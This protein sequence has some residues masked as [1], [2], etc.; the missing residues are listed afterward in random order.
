MFKA[1]KARLYILESWWI[2]YKMSK[3][4]K[5]YKVG[6]V[7]AS[8]F[9][10]AKD[11]GGFSYSFKFQKSYKDKGGQWQTTDGFFLSD[12][13]NL[14]AVAWQAFFDISSK[15]SNDKQEKRTKK[16]ENDNVDEDGEPYNVGRLLE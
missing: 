2:N 12:I 4:I 15:N 13:P 8:V 7:Q 10:N 1:K 11:G 3:P 9:E 6:Q 5:R 16:K 14:I